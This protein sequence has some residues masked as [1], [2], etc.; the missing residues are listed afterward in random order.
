MTWRMI[1]VS[2]MMI[3]AGLSAGVLRP[4]PQEVSPPPSFDAL[5]PDQFGDW[6]RIALGSTIL[7]LETE[8]SF[9]EAVA[10][11]AYRDGAGRIV[12][13][14]VVYGP[15]LGDSVRLHRPE[16]CYVAQGFSINQRDVDELVVNGAPAPVVRLRAASTTRQEAV[17]YLLRDGDAYVVR[18][19]D[20][21]VLKLKR[22]FSGASDGALI[23]VSTTGAD[24]AAFALHNNFLSSFSAALSPAAKKI[25]LAARS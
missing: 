15:P 4:A 6:T 20:H 10:Y 3:V 17:S 7:P 2:A 8:L 24:G 12:T 18:P 11:R 14:V 25:M 21:A 5:L 1:F 16:N 22:G 23:R 19:A 9:G 13:L